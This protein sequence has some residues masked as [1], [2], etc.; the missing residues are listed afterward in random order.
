MEMFSVMCYVASLILAGWDS[1]CQLV[2]IMPKC[3]CEIWI[4]HL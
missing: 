4:E 1:E 3:S 2:G